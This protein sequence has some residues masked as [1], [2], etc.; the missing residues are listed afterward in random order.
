MLRRPTF[1]F[2]L[3]LPRVQIH[4]SAAATVSL[5]LVLLSGT[6]QD[7]SKSL[8]HVA[9]LQIFPFDHNLFT[10]QRASPEKLRWDKLHPGPHRNLEGEA[11]NADFSGLEWP[12]QHLPP[13]GVGWARAPGKLDFG[14]TWHW[15]VE[16]CHFD[17]ALA[18]DSAF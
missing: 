13:R 6:M 14:N 16:T 9:T 11:R 7:K 5:I 1:L 10:W 17:V 4:L 2:S 12:L 3:I 15:S 8:F 18:H